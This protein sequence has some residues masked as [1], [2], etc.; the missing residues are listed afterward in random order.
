MSE[1]N[2]PQVVNI[3]KESFRHPWSARSFRAEL[4]INRHSCYLVARS[5]WE[6]VG[7]I[8][9]WIVLEE[10]HITTL[11]VKNRYRRRGIASFLF[12]ELIGR[13]KPQGVRYITLEVRPSNMPARSFYEKLGF[14]VLGRRRYYY[15]DEDA[16][17]M[18]L[19]D[20]PG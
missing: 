14:K 15:P 16:L 18:S 2:L 4:E 9:A 6:V 3:E 11:A 17:I 20:M 19:E 1:N 13:V 12:N 5:Q 8:G 10:V 7:Y